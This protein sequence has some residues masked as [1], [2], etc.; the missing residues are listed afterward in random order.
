[1]KRHTRTHVGRNLSNV[2]LAENGHLVD[3]LHTHDGPVKS[4]LRSHTGE[5]RFKCDLCGF[6]FASSGGLKMH[7]RTHSG[8][9]P[10][11]CEHMWLVL[12]SEWTTEE[13]HAHTYWRETIQM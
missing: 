11:N 1:M 10:F 7:L 12:C 6:F 2:A 5:K 8:E 9:K 4:Q 13:S 3:H